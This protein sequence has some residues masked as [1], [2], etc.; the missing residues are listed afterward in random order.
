MDAFVFFVLEVKAFVYLTVCMIIVSSVLLK[1]IT[2]PV[3]AYLKKKLKLNYKRRIKF[4]SL[5]QE[6]ANT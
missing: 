2:S 4:S 1:C 5:T 6:N 3:F